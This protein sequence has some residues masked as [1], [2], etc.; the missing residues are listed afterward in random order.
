MIGAPADGVKRE[1]EGTGTRECDAALAEQAKQPGEEVLGGVI[2][3]EA[4]N[5]SVFLADIRI[6][7]NS[8]LRSE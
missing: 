4:K 1:R 8:S 5:L 2:L 6:E 3:S 7:E